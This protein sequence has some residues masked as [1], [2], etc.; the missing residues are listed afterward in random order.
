M[1]IRT[2]INIIHLDDNTSDNRINAQNN[3][4][5]HN[6]NRNPLLNS[7]ELCLICIAHVNIPDSCDRKYEIVHGKSVEVIICNKAKHRFQRIKLAID[8]QDLQS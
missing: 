4:N 6:C 7:D 5:H 3:Y 2:L 1:G 8:T